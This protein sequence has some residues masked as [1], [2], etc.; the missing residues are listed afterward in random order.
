MNFENYPFGRAPSPKIRTLRI[1]ATERMLE[2]KKETPDGQIIENLH[3][4]R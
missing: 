3:P 1:P 4:W 2:L